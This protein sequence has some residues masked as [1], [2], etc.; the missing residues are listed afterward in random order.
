MGAL[1]YKEGLYADYRSDGDRAASLKASDDKVSEG[2]S[3]I[4]IQ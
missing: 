2:Y 4:N 3:C 1:R